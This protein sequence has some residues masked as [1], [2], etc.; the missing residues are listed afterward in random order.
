MSLS[1]LK[2]KIFLCSIFMLISYC[3]LASS[4]L[5]Q[6]AR[7]SQQ[8]GNYDEAIAA[9]RA[10]LTQ[11]VDES[12]LT[13]ESLSMYVEA[14]IQLMN[15]YQSK[16]ESDACIT[17]LED[18][19]EVSPIL[20]DYCL[21]DYYS[22]LGYALSRTERMAEAE[23][24]MLKVF[25]LPL[26]NPT[27]ESYFR[28][29]AYAA[30]VFYSNPSYQNS[31]IIWSKEA[32]RQAELCKNTSGAQ[33]VKSMLGSLY[34]RSGDLHE[35]LNLFHQSRA[36]AEACGDD[37]GLL[38]SINMLVDFLLYWDIP[39]YANIYATEA[40]RVERG[41]AER[42]PMVSTQT[43]INKARALYG[44]SQYDSVMVYTNQARQ[45]CHTLPYNSGMVD[46]DLLR[47]GYFTDKGGDSTNVGISALHQVT[48]QGTALNRAR[49]YHQLAQTYLRD[50]MTAEAEMS[51]DSLYSLL[52]NGDS[53]IY[54][55]VNYEPILAH[56]RQKN[57]SDK[58]DQYVKLMLDEQKTFKSKR[59]NYNLIEGIVDLQMEK[60]SH[61]LTIKDQELQIKD[62]EL[63]IKDQEL[64]I[65]ELQ[66]SRQRLQ[67]VSGLVILI[68]IVSIGVVL[69]YNQRRRFVKL[70]KRANE[71]SASLVEELNKSNVEK[72]RVKQEI[73]EFL[74]DDDN[75]Q[76]LETLTPFILKSDGETKFRQC[77]ELL[78]PLFLPRL[79]DRVPNITRREELLS[80]LIVL[81]QDTKEI[82][83]LLAIAPRSVLM[84]RHRF[85]Q[86]IGIDTEYSLEN[87][88]EDTL[89]QQMHIGQHPEASSTSSDDNS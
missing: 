20:Q 1:V 77:F 16:G 15:T 12:S 69:F 27:P 4:P 34:K 78:Y 18:V 41:M 86:K 39:E 3:S 84:L 43:Y 30:A 53:P 50:G 71:R 35:A 24:T 5:F 73:K 33:W 66:R 40:V 32:L 55:S 56:Y 58:V 59:L 17:A 7:S 22:V 45:L 87:F 13:D 29:Y 54:I 79:R 10:F 85:R 6:Q 88:I 52:N 67:L 9:Y 14:L 8:S 21:R 81:K 2:K 19:F 83:E 68:L 76:E 42:N 47:G 25:T 65:V 36:E 64:N 62:Q 80:M 75:R 11:P 51:L 70:M 48:K 37:L 63:H 23:Q 38:N 44:I 28:D 60:K 49:A 89:G 26:H 72:E 82:S 61:Q 57:S 74:K 46:V 31:V